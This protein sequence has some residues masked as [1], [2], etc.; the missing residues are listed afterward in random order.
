MYNY[1]WWVSIY[2]IILFFVSS[3]MSLLKILS[4]L[5]L[6]SSIRMIGEYFMILL[7]SSIFVIIGFV[8]LFM[9]IHFSGLYFL[10]YTLS[11]LRFIYPITSGEQLSIPLHD[12]K[13]RSASSRREIPEALKSSIISLN[14]FMNDL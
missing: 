12:V 14:S 5:T 13:H 6:M 9:R 8:S 11:P 1:F 3:R 10:L 4:S 7:L 2:E